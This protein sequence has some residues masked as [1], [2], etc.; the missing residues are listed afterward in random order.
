MRLFRD[1]RAGPLAALA[2]ALAT[3][4]ATGC[5]SPDP[6]SVRGSTIDVRLEEFRFVPQAIRASA[7]RVTIRVRNEGVLAHNLKLFRRGVE[8]VGTDTIQHGMPASTT[9]TLRRGTYR[10]VCTIA[11]HDDLG[12]YGSLVVR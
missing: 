8:V 11:N 6:V 3:L 5:G 12:M 10:M 2:T 1:R 9:V 7:G 4:G